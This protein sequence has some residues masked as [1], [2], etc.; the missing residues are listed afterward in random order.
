MNQSLFYEKFVIGMIKMGQ[1]NVLTGGQGEIRN[2]CD[3]RNKAKKV[4]I[5]TV[6]E[7]LEETF[8]A[9]F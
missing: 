7:E 4:D 9:L 5:A 2:R 1:M 3:R 6:V 8:S